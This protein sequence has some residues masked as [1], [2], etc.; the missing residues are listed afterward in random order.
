MFSLACMFAGDNA[1]NSLCLDEINSELSNIVEIDEALGH[2]C[3]HMY[4]IY[5]AVEKLVFEHE[6]GQFDFLLLTSSWHFSNK[7]RSPLLKAN[8]SKTSSSTFSAKAFTSH[9]LTH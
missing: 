8:V 6:W 7:S 1:C 9:H 4:T 5:T 3:S 2:L